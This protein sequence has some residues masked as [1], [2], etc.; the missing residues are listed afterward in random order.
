MGATL[1]FAVL[2]MLGNLAADVIYAV[3]DPRIRYD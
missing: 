2:T 3:A 1:M